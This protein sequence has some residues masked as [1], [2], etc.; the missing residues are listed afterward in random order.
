MHL[1]SRQGQ[2]SGDK[3]PGRIIQ[4]ILNMNIFRLTIK[5]TN[6]MKKKI[7]VSIFTVFLFLIISGNDA[8]AQRRYVDH[9][10]VDG[11]SIQYRWANSKWLD[12]NSRLEL[13]LKIKNNND[14]PVEVSY[15]IDFLM[16]PMVKE[17]SDVTNICISPKLARTGRLNG[18]YYQSSRLNNKDIE[19]DEFS[20]EIRDLEIEQVESCR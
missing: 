9:S 5:N 11:I 18:M 20:W 19:S 7:G 3:R 13:R 6:I 2:E 8:L 14:Y 17:S 10:T 16:G 4:G 1:K 15:E 12:K